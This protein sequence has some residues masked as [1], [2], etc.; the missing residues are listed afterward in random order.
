MATKVIGVQFEGNLKPYYFDPRKFEFTVGQ[1]CVVETVFGM[2]LGKVVSPPRLVQE[3]PKSLKPAVRPAQAIDLLQYQTNKEKAKEAFEIAQA[4]IAE[5]ALPMKLLQAHYTLDRSRLTFYFGAEERVDFRSL[6]K[7]LAAIF[8]TRI[9]LRQMGVRDEAR[10]IGGLGMCG[11]ELCCNCFLG[12]FSPVSIKMAKEQNLALNSAKISGICGR[13]MCCLAFEY[14][15][16]RKLIY[17][18]PK[19]GSKVFTRR[20]W[21]K[22]IQVDIFKDRI[23]VELDNG[24][25][26]SIGEEEYNRYFL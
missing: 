4:K 12:N 18:L 5:H 20:G 23:L 10:M 13:L 21:G 22:I 24:Q 15:L 14:P 7:D 2:E 8:R 25:E 6:V 9:E 3:V 16:Y 11:R 19:R 1:M 17:K 26:I